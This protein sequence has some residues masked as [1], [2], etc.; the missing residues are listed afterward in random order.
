MPYCSSEVYKSIGISP[1]FVNLCYMEDG[2][3]VDD[4]RIGLNNEI[5]LNNV[6][7]FDQSGALNLGYSII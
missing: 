4:V 6:E 5:M 7:T 3:T 2:Y 1:K